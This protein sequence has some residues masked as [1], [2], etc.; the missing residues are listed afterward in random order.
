MKQHEREFFISLIR[1]GKVYIQYENIELIIK[2]PTFE[3]NI[4]ACQVYNKSYEEAYIEEVMTQDETE[5]WM[6]EHGLW[7]E[8]DDEK[9]KGLEK[10]IEKLKIEIYNARNNDQLK[11]KIR[12]YIRAGEVQLS[13]QIN[14]KHLYFANT[15][16]GIASLEKTS[17][18][19][20][21]TTY[22]NEKL[23]DF[24]DVSLSYIMNEWQSSFLTEKQCRELARTEPWK[25]FWTIH[26]KAKVP[27]FENK[28]NEDLTYNQKNLTIWSQMYDNIQESMDCPNNEVINDDDM[29]DGWFIV[30]GKKREKEKMEKEFDDSIKNDKIKNSSEIFVMAN[31]KKQKDRVDSMNDPHA[32]MVKKQREQLIKRKG[33]VSQQEF[34]DERLKIQS[35]TNN[36]YIGKFKGGK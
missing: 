15:C 11:E 27:L 10:D 8:E 34:Q 26:E 12:L 17:F 5:Q 19:I 31:N 32:N 22:L 33:S 13:E 20:K 2:P 29:L 21:N 14:K 23:Y 36:M 18:I 28:P 16:E 9:I 25:S 1:T 30:Q 3:D 7:T 24:D 6:I 4:R 35:Q